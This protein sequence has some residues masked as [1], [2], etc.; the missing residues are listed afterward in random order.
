[1]AFISYAQNYED[2]MLWRTLGHVNCGFYIDIGATD[3]EKDSVTKAFYDRGW[4]GINVEPDLTL[5]E[6]LKL[7][8]NRDINLPI[9]IGDQEGEAEFSPATETSL[10]TL[11]WSSGSMASSNGLARV[12]V[13]RL[14]GIWE[15]YVPTDQDV[16]FL[17]VDVD[18]QE[19]AVLKKHDWIRF[20]PWL[21]VVAAN[22]PLT[23]TEHYAEWEPV[24][25][26]A[27]YSFAYADGLNR[28]YV[29]QE[30]SA[31]IAAFKYPPNLFDDFVKASQQQQLEVISKALHQAEDALKIE[32]DAAYFWWITASETYA[33]LQSIYRS[34]FWQFSQPLR[35]F[36][37]SLF[38]QSKDK[39][40]AP[41][42]LPKLINQQVQGAFKATLFR[43]I[44]L[45]AGQPVLKTR[46]LAVIY[47]NPALETR[48]RKVIASRQVS[49]LQ[50][51]PAETLS[52]EDRNLKTIDRASSILATN[53]AINPDSP[54][55]TLDKIA[56]QIM[57]SCE[58]R[59]LS[60]GQEEQ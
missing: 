17:K 9:A 16:H 27:Q 13:K 22:I 38:F 4:C 47:G 58:A 6:A 48:I 30:H 15:A 23:S 60:S 51:D 28:F 24:L 42:N 43:L 53:I 7:A 12:P 2:V 34:S 18:G 33:E 36:F 35:L 32:Q 57:L 46:I 29:A 8:R 21:V 20:R 26:N 3:P 25:T 50:S 56:H 55:H 59:I 31:L 10:S 11:I 54:G 37:Q 1:M 44:R 19:L 45:V 52:S 14:P 41:S 5:F 49:T 40:T 39:R